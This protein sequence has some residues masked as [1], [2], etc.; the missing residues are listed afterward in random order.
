MKQIVGCQVKA[1]LL[2]KMVPARWGTNGGEGN[3][4]IRKWF[5]KWF[6]LE[7]VNLHLRPSDSLLLNKRPGF[8][9]LLSPF[10]LELSTNPPEGWL[11]LVTEVTRGKTGIE[12]EGFFSLPPCWLGEGHFLVYPSFNET[13]AGAEV[14]SSSHVKRILRGIFFYLPWLV[15]L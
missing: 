4:V 9:E 3:V 8:S 6:D 13:W 14:F 1:R 15:L 12:G 7:E 5:Q 10:P 11:G 2:L